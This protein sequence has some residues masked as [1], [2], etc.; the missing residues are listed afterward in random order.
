M[1]S[2]TRP[3]TARQPEK[4]AAGSSRFKT[5]PTAKRKDRLKGLKPMATNT[6]KPSSNQLLDQLAAKIRAAFEDA[7]KHRCSALQCSIDAGDALLQAQEQVTTGWTRWLRTNC[8]ASERPGFICMKLARYRAELEVRLGRGGEL[9][10][11]AALRLIAK[12][13][14]KD[15]PKP[16][17][18]TRLRSKVD[19][20]ITAALVELGLERFLGVMPPEWRPKIQRQAGGQAV[21]ILKQQHANVRLRNL[22]S[23]HLEL[24]G[25]NTPIMAVGTT[26]PTKTTH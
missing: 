11:R 7:R 4:F 25:D 12:L 23:R 9:S 3:T 19:A 10:V 5:E 16:K 6:P 2:S 26:V 8:G 24:V 14:G 18:P 21:S 17:L 22:K 13:E 15:K 20:E 1:P